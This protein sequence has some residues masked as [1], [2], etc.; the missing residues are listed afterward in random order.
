MT[1]LPLGSLVTIH[2]RES[3]KALYQIIGYRHIWWSTPS[4]DL[5]TFTD[6]G[7]AHYAQTLWGTK[8][9]EV[10]RPPTE[11][12]SFYYQVKPFLSKTFKT[13]KYRISPFFILPSGVTAFDPDQ[14]IAELKKQIE[15][16]SAKIP[17]IEQIRDNPPS[18]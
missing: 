3:S 5:E 17:I 6:D 4:S 11:P 9:R 1:M 10:A 13:R 14:A 8:V 18:L 12:N 7:I 16:L 2:S 15:D